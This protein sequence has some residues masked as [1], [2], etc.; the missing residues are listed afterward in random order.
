MNAAT[1]LKW[2]HPR[3]V[4][5]IFSESDLARALVLPCPPDIFELRLDGLR[6]VI[7]RLA[8]AITQLG[9]PLIITARSPAEGGVGS[10]CLACRRDLLLRFLGH[11]TFVDIELH[12]ARA[13]AI[14]REQ[15]GS[16]GVSLILSWH[17][18]KTTP[19]RNTLRAAVR[20]ARSLGAD[21]FKI[22]TRIDRGDQLDRLV[23]ITRWASTYLPIS[24]MG[25]GRLGRESRRQLAYAGS[26][27]N[28]AHLGRATVEGQWSLAQLHAAQAPS[29]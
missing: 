6:G 2:A 8:E 27:L 10:L 19:D 29:G 1:G 18:L 15:A 7:G 23:D 12:S 20:R 25:F 16:R 28:Y 5:V 14:V 13:L 11:S 21:I 4:G 3:S 17:N 26:I 24:A 9:K 22:A